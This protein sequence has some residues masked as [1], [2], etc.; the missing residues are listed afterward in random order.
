ME[1]AHQVVTVECDHCESIFKS[2]SYLENHVDSA[3]KVITFEC[4]HC[5]SVFKS[6]SDMKNHV[7]SFHTKDDL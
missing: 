2:E 1:S 3:N 7:D 5:E 6:E 4:D